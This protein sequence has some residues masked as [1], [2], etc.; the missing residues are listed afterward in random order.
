MKYILLFT[1]II[2]IGNAYYDTLKLEVN[3]PAQ[4]QIYQVQQFD[5]STR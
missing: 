2:M 5:S 4:L 1:Y 3:A